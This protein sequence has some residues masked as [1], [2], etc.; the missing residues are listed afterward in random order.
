V[1]SLSKILSGVATVSKELSYAGE[2]SFIP[3]RLREFASN[4]I[5]IVVWN[6]TNRCN[7]NCI[8]CYARANTRKAELS[9]EECKRIINELSEFRV[10]MILFSGGEP[11]L[12]QDIFE[13]AEYAKKK[14][15]RVVLSTNGT[16]IDESN[17]D[18]IGIFDYVGISLDGIKVHDRFR[19][20]EGAFRKALRALEI[21]SEVTMTG[22]RFTLTK[23]NFLELPEL[24]E[25]AIDLG[26]PRFCVYHLVPSGKASFEDDVDNA[27]RKRIVNFLMEK[28]E[29]EEEM[30]ILTVDNPADGVYAYLQ[31]QRE[32]ILEFLKFRGGDSSGVRLACIDE[33]GNL[34][35]NQF[36]LD[37]NAG[38]VLVH[39]FRDLWLKDPLFKKLREKEKYLQEKC[40][41]CKFK[42]VCGG[43]R[44]RALRFGN[45]WGWDPSCYIFKS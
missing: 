45:L 37:Y 30:E 3:R 7:L 20:I 17:V 26:I 39:G 15:I 38:N 9:T 44:V 32:E 28:A 16:L 13:I 21:S 27:T 33:L 18:D 19:G 29:R 2:N 41:V 22:I 25:L 14:K 12:R 5:P 43:F 31:T 10:P 40:G 36:W 4:Q 23:H 11:L 35:P 1:I 24:I 42:S 34:H 8:H 6:I